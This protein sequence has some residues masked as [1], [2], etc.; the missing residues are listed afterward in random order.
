MRNVSHSGSPAR[1]LW[2]STAVT[3]VLVLALA[4][5]VTAGRPGEVQTGAFA[6]GDSPA[7]PVVPRRA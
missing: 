5:Q 1:G 7:C 4:A 2:L 6:T 3:L